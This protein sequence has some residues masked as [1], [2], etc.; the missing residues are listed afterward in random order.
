MNG[1]STLFS[2]EPKADI[3]SPHPLHGVIFEHI[4]GIVADGKDRRNESIKLNIDDSV[5]KMCVC[6][7]MHAIHTPS[8]FA[9]SSLTN[10]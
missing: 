4:G 2:K 8:S 10:F 3:T 1:F 5:K 7:R 6:V 9:F